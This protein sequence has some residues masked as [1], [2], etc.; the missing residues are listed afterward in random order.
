MV[1][2]R[3]VWQIGC[4]MK[5]NG[6]VKD[7]SKWVYTQTLAEFIMKYDKKFQRE[8]QDVSNRDI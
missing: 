2:Y 7:V 4:E 3:D 6:E 8:I 1:S 5:W